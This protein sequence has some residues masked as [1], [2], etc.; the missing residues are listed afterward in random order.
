MFFN[1]FNSNMPMMPGRF[2]EVMPNQVP[3]QV[4]FNS[5]GREVTN[6]YFG[7]VTIVHHKNFD[8][9]NNQYNMFNQIQQMQRLITDRIVENNNRLLEDLKHRHNAQIDNTNFIERNV[10]E[11]QIT[12]DKHIKLIEQS[13]K[14][15]DVEFEVVAEERNE[16]EIDKPILSK[17]LLGNFKTVIRQKHDIIESVYK[18]K[19]DK[20]ANP[21]L[22]SECDGKSVIVAHIYA[23]NENWRTRLKRSVINKLSAPLVDKNF[24]KIDQDYI[25][26]LYTGDDLNI[27]SDCIYIKPVSL[28][29]FIQGKCE[30]NEEIFNRIKRIIELSKDP[31]LEI[32]RFTYI[33]E[34]II[35]SDSKISVLGNSSTYMAD[36]IVIN[37]LYSKNINKIA[38]AIELY[39]SAILCVKFGGK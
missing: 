18:Q 38:I 17:N 20:D 33:N 19:N 10:T 12:N 37:P 8:D 2:Q 25:I 5:N 1:N 21:I 34:P 16:K 11:K 29:T 28:K 27:V 24:F 35:S 23:S 7:D 9:Y 15:S 6:N 13:E 4:P 36:C 3:N 31:L 26:Y 30:I 14:I 32:R 39:N 22:I